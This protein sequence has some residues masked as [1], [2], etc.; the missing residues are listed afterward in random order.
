[1]QSVMHL[2]QLLQG[3]T[4]TCVNAH[5]CHANLPTRPGA[6]AVHVPT[7]PAD[8]DLMPAGLASQPSQPTNFHAH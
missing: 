4:L 6:L 3:R 1:M 5:L 8:T 2:W 7:L